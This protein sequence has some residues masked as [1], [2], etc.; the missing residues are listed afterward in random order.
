MRENSMI[1][2][3]FAEIAVMRA[4]RGSDIKAKYTHLFLR[5]Y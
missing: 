3:N 5:K 2:G 1:A 4:A